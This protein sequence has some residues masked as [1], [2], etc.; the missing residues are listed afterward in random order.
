MALKKVAINGMFW[1]F[2]DYFFVKGLSFIGTIILARIL[3]PSD[4]GLIAMISIFITIGTVLLDGGLSSSL[5][6]NKNNNHEDYST[7]FY[8]NIISGISIYLLFFL[9]APFIS[10][11]FEYGILTK[12]IRVYT[13][14]FILSSFSSVQMSILIQKMSFKKIAFL[15]LPGTIIGLSVGIIA[16]LN[17]MGVWSLISMYLVTQMSLSI[18]LWISSDWKPTF[19]FSNSKFKYHFNYG[20]K[21]LLSNLLS[22]TTTNINAAVVGKVYP[23]NT[24]GFFE[25]AY[26]LNSYPLMILTQIIGKVSFPLLASVQDE[27]ERVLIVFKKLVRHTFFVNAPMMLI[28]SACAEPL[29]LF[30]LGEKWVG[31]VPIFQILCFSGMF[32]TLQALN[33]NMIKTYG[34]T[35]YILRGEIYL[36]LFM[37]ISIGI[38]VFIS[39]NTFLWSIVLNSFLTLIVNM[40][41]CGKVINSTIKDQLFTILPIFLVSLLTFLSVIYLSRYIDSLNFSNGIKLIILAFF[42]TI[43]YLGAS[44]L[45]K[46]KSALELKTLI[47][48]HKIQKI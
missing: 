17:G 41:Y 3:M 37:V 27:K 36:K 5:I 38:S 29:I 28:L 44:L 24:A 2:I 12:L 11:F 22:G 42:G 47:L 45:F 6:R 10:I 20:Y 14:T 1:V 30:L 46:V 34:R 48:N 19:I 13:I 25:R 9:L 8:T 16:A 33:V 43:F 26:M 21:L 23:I 15:N 31:A 32:Y 40:Y 18:G 35:D 7:V 4:F 39:F